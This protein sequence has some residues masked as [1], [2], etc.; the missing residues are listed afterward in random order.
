MN[1]VK[2]IWEKE[3]DDLLDE[4]RGYSE[5]TCQIPGWDPVD[6][7]MGLKWMRSS[8]YEGYYVEYRVH[9]KEGQAIIEFKLW[10]YGDDEPPW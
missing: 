3:R 5:V 4:I 6:L 1:D 7:A 10:E 2:K 8:I 9:E